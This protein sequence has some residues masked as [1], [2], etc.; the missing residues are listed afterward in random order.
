MTEHQPLD[1]VE[2]EINNQL[3]LLADNANQF[4][5]SDAAWT[6][7]IKNS[8][9]RLGVSLGYTVYAAECDFEENGEWLFDMVWLE[10]D[11]WVRSVP[12]V[13]E[14]EWTPKEVWDDFEKL[15]VARADHRVM[16]LWARTET[17]ARTRI[18]ELIKGVAAYRRTEPGDRYL[19]ACWVDELDHFLTELYVSPDPKG[20]PGA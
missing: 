6:R 8:L 7:A 10:Q 4:A 12:L 16:V 20:V 15:L 19:F 2:A 11:E 1:P 5:D 13:M 18:E 14:S 9:G 17:Q 3:A